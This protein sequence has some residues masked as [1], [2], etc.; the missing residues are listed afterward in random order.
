MSDLLEK[1][2]SIR[3]YFVDEA[4]NPTLFNS[5]GKVIIQSEGC[6]RFFLLGVL[7]VVE[8]ESL[9]KNL[10][11]LRSD[12]LADPYFKKV[13]YMQ[14]GYQKIAIAFHA[15][16]DIPEVRREVFNLLKKLELKFLAVI[17]H[18]QKVSQKLIRGDI[19]KARRDGD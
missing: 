5:K 15:K 13:P 14:P 2:P 16:D 19:L 3:Y 10:E 1:A 6:S 4:G 18:K 8:P 9:I 7:D 17:R 12:L 11:E